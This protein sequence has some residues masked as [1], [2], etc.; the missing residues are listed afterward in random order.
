MDY[1]LESRR[2]LVHAIHESRRYAW[3]TGKGGMRFSDGR[4]EALASGVSPADVVQ[5]AMALTMDGSRPWN[6][7][8]YP[9][10]CLHLRWVIRSLISNLATSADNRQLR[11][12][13]EEW[14]AAEAQEPAEA[15][16]LRSAAGPE[17][18]ELSGRVLD[19]VKDDPVLVRV[20]G[21]LKEGRKPRHVAELMGLA[22]KDVYRLTQKLRRRLAGVLAAGV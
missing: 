4:S 14:S 11:Q 16:I 8:K 15:E 17:A 5:E 19:A 13:P 3:R 22:E 18:E 2:L 9:D 6:K 20:L 7:E 10:I 12:V 21:H 1:S